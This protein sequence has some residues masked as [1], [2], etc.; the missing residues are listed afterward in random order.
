MV[1]DGEAEGLQAWLKAYHGNEENIYG[2]HLLQP[3]SH[4]M[5]VVAGGAYLTRSFLYLRLE[6]SEEPLRVRSGAIQ[7]AL[8][9]D[10]AGTGD[11]NALGI[12][13]GMP[14]VFAA[15]YSYNGF[16]SG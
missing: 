12:F 6:H 13:F 16:A 3:C 5:N 11:Y 8:N 2:R 7:A 10:F 9:L 15:W 4:G 1:S 14:S